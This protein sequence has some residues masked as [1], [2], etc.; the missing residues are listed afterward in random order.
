MARLFIPGPTDVAQETLAAQTRPM[1]GHRGQDSEAL[2]ASL[3][4]RLRR[5][6]QTTNRVFLAASSGTGLWEG[7]MRNTIRER[8]LLCVCGAFG[9]R[10]VE[11]AQAN[12]LPHDVLTAEWGQPNLPEDVEQA[13]RLRS[14]D[15]L[16][17]VHNE[18]STGVE[19]PIADVARLAREINPEIVILVD[20]VSSAGGVDLRTDAWEIDVMLTSSQKCFALPPGLSFAAVSDR[21][22]RRAATIPHRGWYFDFLRL[23]EYLKQDTTPATPAISLMYALDVQLDRMLAEGLGPRFDRHARMAA[24]VQQWCAEH[25]DL[26]AADGFRSKTV[27]T[28]TN[29]RSIDVRRLN[30]FL[31]QRQMT[32][33][34]GYGPLKGKTFRIAH[35]GE[36]M[37]DDLSRLMAAMDEFLAAPA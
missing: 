23:E 1:I 29:T 10:W 6:F 4:A 11:V 32:I 16:A 22:L 35:M 8:A 7:S 2:F 20:A 5:V 34:N 28:A 9:G 17:I 31:L 14:Y 30:Q 13:L 12:G 24:M 36:I 18:T 15:T 19:N 37:P 33:A 21:A 26:F 25:F 3:Q 27:T